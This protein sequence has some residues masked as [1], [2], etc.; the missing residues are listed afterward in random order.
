MR[1]VQTNSAVYAPS[2][3]SRQRRRHPKG[4]AKKRPRFDAANGILNKTFAPIIGRDL[5]MLGSPREIEREFYHSLSNFAALYGLKIP[6]AREEYPLNITQAFEVVKQQFSAL[7]TGLQVIILKE[8]KHKACVTTVKTYDT[9]MCLFYIAV[10]P[11]VL[12]LQNPHKKTQANLL[13]SVFA[14][15]RQVAGVPDF[16][17]GF[18]GGYYQTIQEWYTQDPRDYDEDVCNELTSTYR[19]ME[20]FGRKVFKSIRNKYH[21][22]QFENRVRS[23]APKTANDREL[24]ATGTEILNLYLAYPER[25]IMDNMYY[26]FFEPEQEDRILPDQYISFFWEAEG[27]VYEQLMEC[28]NV[29]FQEICC[30]EEPLSFQLFDTPQTAQAHSLVFEETFFECLHKL[31]DLLDIL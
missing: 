11:L 2:R 12:L 7:D 23:F 28:I 29:D 21:L 14:Y 22:E 6:P 17:D 15:L 18:V 16:H 10:K 20:Y 5:G 8:K 31:A 9:G 26:G 4:Q 27:M 30:I 24:L 25:R 3:H 13:L 1:S 19:S